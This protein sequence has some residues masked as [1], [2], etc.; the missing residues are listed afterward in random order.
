MSCHDPRKPAGAVERFTFDSRGLTLVGDRRAGAASRPA[1]VF[2]H[3]GGQTRH[4]WD[5]TAAQLATAGWETFQLDAR[6]HGESDWDPA[7]DYGAAAF[8]RDLDAF[9]DY[10]GRPVVLIGASLGGLTALAVAAERPDSVVGLVLVDVVVEFEPSGADRIRDFMVGNPD[11]FSSLE[12]VADAVAAYNPHRRRPPTVDGLRRNVKRGEDG[13]WRWHWDPA[14]ASPSADSRRRVDTERLGA[15]A[16]ARIR[17][18]TLLVRGM[19]SDV[20]SD[21]GLA[22][23]RRRIPSAE[24]IAVGD[25][26]HMV[27]GDDNDIFTEALG[28]FLSRLDPT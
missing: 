12:E 8:Q 4:S 2:L 11:G 18:P 21:A 6:G 27:V 24:V 14:F 19:Q 25:A 17:A 20:V 15:T 23:M 10:S 22:D 16:A 5:R 9:L 3:G 1:L 13:R 28:G 26:G 7:G